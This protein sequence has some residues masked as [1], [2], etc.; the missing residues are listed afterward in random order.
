M[1][2]DNRS[3]FVNTCRPIYSNNN[4]LVKLTYS[5]MYYNDTIIFNTLIILI[6]IYYNII[7]YETF[8]H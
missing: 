7:I 4:L 3:E 5:N 1:V 2:R 6:N 8:Y